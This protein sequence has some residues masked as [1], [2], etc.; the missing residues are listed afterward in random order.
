[1][2]ELTT[3]SFSTLLKYDERNNLTNSHA[4][5]GMNFEREYAYNKSNQLILSVH[6]AQGQIT[7]RTEY[8]YENDHLSR[9]I[10]NDN[11]KKHKVT[12]LYKFD[13]YNNWVEQEKI[14][15]GKIFIRRRIITYY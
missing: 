4:V 14:I 8:F 3:L 2:G 5:G 6:K 13:H 1:M 12:F 10:S 11:G 7:E 9:L 15:N